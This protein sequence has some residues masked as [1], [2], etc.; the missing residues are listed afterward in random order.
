MSYSTWTDYYSVNELACLNCTFSLPFVD[1]ESIYTE[2][3]QSIL[4]RYGKKY[5]RESK[6]RAMGRPRLEAA[7]VVVDDAGIPL[8]AEEFSKE[9]YALLFQRFPT[10]KYMPGI[11]LVTSLLLEFCT[12]AGALQI[13]QHLHAR[14]VPLALATS[15]HT[16]AFESK[17][18]QKPELIS[19]FLHTVCGDSPEVK[20]GK[21]SPDIFLV[22]ASKFDPPP[23]SMDKVRINK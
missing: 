18:S 1:T 6:I 12:L 21:P 3:T 8:T 14:G 17:I 9:L 4:D 15:S 7:Q 23:S 13:L 10:A 19:C 11:L 20:R 22:A 2:C 5:T 16:A